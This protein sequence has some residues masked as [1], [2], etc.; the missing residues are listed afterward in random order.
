[1]GSISGDRAVVIFYVYLAVCCCGFGG[2][3]RVINW[4][5]TDAKRVSEHSGRRIFGR[6]G[7]VAWDG[8]GGDG[9]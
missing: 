5:P 1:M 3:K 6:G 8:K 4:S 9:R 2:V 7:R